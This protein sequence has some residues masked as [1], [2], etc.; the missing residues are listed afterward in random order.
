MEKYNNKLTIHEF[1]TT[2]YVSNQSSTAELTSPSF[3]LK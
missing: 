1:Q 2:I 3:S